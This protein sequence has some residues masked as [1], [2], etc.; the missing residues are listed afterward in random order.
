VFLS[1]ASDIRLSSD[2]VTT[3]DVEK[4]VDVDTFGSGIASALARAA[5]LACAFAFTSTFGLS[6]P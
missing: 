3:V 6:S 1:A 4:V 5:A 2:A